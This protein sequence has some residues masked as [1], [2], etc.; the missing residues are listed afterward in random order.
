MSINKRLLLIVIIA[1]FFIISCGGS[2]EDD[3]PTSNASDGPVIY[4]PFN[5]NANDESGNGND[6]IVTGAV[7]APDKDGN[8]SSAYSFSGVS[9]YIE[10][11]NNINIAGNSARTACAWV[12]PAQTFP[13]SCCPTPFSWGEPLISKGFGNF[14]NSGSWFFW[15]FVDDFNT[16]VSVNTE[17]SFHCVTYDSTTVKYYINGE[18]MG[19]QVKNL[20]T[21]NSHLVIGD[22]FDHRTGIF[23]TQFEGLIDEVSI[24]NR[25]LPQS[26]IQNLFAK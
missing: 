22:G 7:L 19:N 25:A 18:D 21:T 6:G 13:T 24:Y 10:S 2:S 1:S 16:N 14:I 11:K 23:S 8:V 12:K 20:D 26:E 4:Y 5:G 15:G 17:W 9:N 3:E